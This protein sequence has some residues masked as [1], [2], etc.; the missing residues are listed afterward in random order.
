MG[1][2]T[3]KELAHLL[4]ISV[5]SVSKALNDSHE[6]SE[7]TKIRVRKLANKYN[8]RPNILA[9]SLKTGRSNTIGIIIPYLGN[10]FQSQI[11]EGAH[12]AAYNN[13]YKLVF[14]QSRE[15]AE[16][17]K[18]SLY[19]L[20][21]QNIDGIL[22][23]PCANSDGQVLHEINKKKPVV[24]IDRIEY[25]L[26]T[27]KIG[28]DSELGSY[29]ATQHLIDQGRKKI[30]VL[31]GQNIG[32]TK[33]RL[34]GYKKALM[35]N[36]IDF[37]ES[38]VITVDYGQ[39]SKYLISNLRRHLQDLLQNIKEPVGLFGT[40]DT[41]T[42]SSLGILAELGYKVPDD[43]AV[44]G[45]ANTEVADSLNPPLSTIV[46]PAIDIGQKGVEKLIGLITARN[47]AFIEHE[48]IKFNP[49]IVIRKSTTTS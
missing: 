38:L 33:E 6:I 17:E 24:L 8:Y 18:E 9:K 31:T 37:D 11:L 21:Q 34:S 35:A 32:V 13:N 46:Q 25:D 12:L 19:A 23:S 5:S 4:G 16:L 3:L 1:N 7:E 20:I 22:I 36:Y 45:F 14:M 42:V 10:P 39:N 48:T 27:H 2:I 47:R 43:V 28:S 41:L 29:E 15:N 44:I 26:D 30:I 40:T 49:L